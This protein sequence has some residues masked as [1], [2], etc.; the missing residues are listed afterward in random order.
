[1]MALAVPALAQESSPDTEQP[2]E[3]QERSVQ[4]ASSKPSVGINDIKPIP[5]S[6]VVK[7]VERMSDRVV[8]AAQGVALPA[9]PMLIVAAAVL[10]LI[11]AA[12]ASF[13]KSFVKAGVG[14][15][16]GLFIGYVLIFHYDDIIGVLKGLGQG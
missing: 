1:M 6:E 4:D 15:L 8:E 7:A 12:V 9:I 14:L 3:R 2:A 11:G 10:L 13:T 16:T 5:P